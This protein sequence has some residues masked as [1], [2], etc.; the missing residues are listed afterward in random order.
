M[1]SDI[2]TVKIWPLP[3]MVAVSLTIFAAT[4]FSYAERHRLR[5]EGSSFPA[6]IGIGTFVVAMFILTA[7]TLPKERRKVGLIFSIVAGETV[8]FIGALMFLLLNI[9]G[10]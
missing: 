6:V 5:Q 2:P 10:S 8:V 1:R 7:A 4:F 3:V 9:F